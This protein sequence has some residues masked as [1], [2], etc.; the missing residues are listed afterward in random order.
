[1]D[2]KIYV[3]DLKLFNEGKL[4][5]TWIDL[6]VCDEEEVYTRIQE[7]LEDNE[8][9]AIHDYELPF[10]ISDYDS[11][12]EIMEKVEFVQEFVHDEND[13]EKLQAIIEVDGLPY[14][15]NDWNRYTLIE[16]VTTYEEVGLY[17]YENGLMG[18][19]IPD[20]LLKYFDFEKYGCDIVAE[21]CD[22]LTDYGYLIYC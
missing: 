13:E 20:E 22:N 7:M 15:M 9:W 17:W 2:L 14:A 3:V 16:H 8:E 18:F 12:P 11:I 1:M 21:G 5:G 19:E 10:K 4:K 6:M